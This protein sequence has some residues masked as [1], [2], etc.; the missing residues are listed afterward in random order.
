MRYKK[1]KF[2]CILAVVMLFCMV[3]AKWRYDSDK[4]IR[5]Y[6]VVLEEYD[7]AQNDKDYT[8][9]KWQYVFD[10]MAG[11]IY[12][13]EEL[14]YCFSD[15]NDDKV[16][17]LIIGV[18]QEEN[19]NTYVVYAYVDGDI[20]RAIE[21]GSYAIDIYRNGIVKL[22]GGYV[23]YD[24]CLYYSLN[25]PIKTVEYLGQLTVEEKEEKKYYYLYDGNETEITEE[26]FYGQRDLWEDVEAELEWKELDG[27]WDC[28]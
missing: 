26:E 20:R 7:K 16:P 9:E 11:A 27:F 4:G 1:K 13:N 6:K 14:G 24:F 28:E 15:F 21:K 17:E 5:I 3:I 18:K 2:L 12:R 22:R 25:N 8:V 19:Y 10:E 23:G